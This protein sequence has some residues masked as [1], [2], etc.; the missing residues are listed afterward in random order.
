MNYANTAIFAEQGGGGVPVIPSTPNSFI[1]EINTTLTT[2]N[3]SAAN[4]WKIPFNTIGAPFAVDFTIVWGDGTADYITST[5]QAE[6]L[7]TYPAPGVYNAY[8]EGPIIRNIKGI[9]GTN[10][11]FKWVGISQWGNLEINN[12]RVFADAERIIITATDSP[13]FTTSDCT[14]CF[15][16]VRGANNDF[17]MTNWDISSITNANQMFYNASGSKFTGFNTAFATNNITNFSFM[18]AILFGVTDGRLDASDMDVTGGNLRSMF[19]ATQIAFSMANWD[20]TGVTDLTDFMR[21]NGGFVNTSDYDATLISWSNQAD[22]G[23]VTANVSRVDFGNSKYT[24]GG[25]AEAA[26]TNLITTHGW[27]IT[28]GGPA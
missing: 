8:M 2:T 9:S 10:D 14:R 11:Y 6:I 16:N 7:H 17:Y 15:R 12:D 20:L 27:V 3:S 21:S 13:T 4:Q 24:A 28:D 26:R 25:A 5:D 18:F 23:N 22:L 19:F 1:F